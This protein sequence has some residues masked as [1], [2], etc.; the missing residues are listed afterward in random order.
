MEQNF[1][2]YNLLNYFDFFY[3]INGRF[4]NTTGHLYVPDG[5]KPQEVEGDILN[6]KKLYE[7]FRGSNSHG[8][9]SLP[10][11]CALNLYLGGEEQTS[12]NILTEIYSNLSLGALFSEETSAL[13]F[14][15]LAD[16]CAEI[17]I[18]LNNAATSNR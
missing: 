3:Y 10:F 6:M 9:V 1:G 11:L 7:K 16:L 12:K 18:F 2:A 17:N 15:K 4:P 13:N 14:R 8:L 5:E